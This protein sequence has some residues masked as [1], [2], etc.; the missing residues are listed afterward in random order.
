MQHNITRSASAQQVVSFFPSL[1]VDDVE[2][3]G[4]LFAFFPGKFV[5]FRK[6]NEVAVLLAVLLAVDVGIGGLTARNGDDVRVASP[7]VE[8]VVYEATLFF[9]VEVGVEVTAPVLVVLHASDPSDHE[10]NTL[11]VLD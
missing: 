11:K 6:Y 7:E 9:Q 10:R 1:G 3:R 8:A 4:S 2:V 5:S